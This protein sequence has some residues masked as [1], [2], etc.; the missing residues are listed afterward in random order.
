LWTAIASFVLALLL[1][2]IAITFFK[3]AALV[4]PGSS[5]P[6]ALMQG[7][8]ALAIAVILGLFWCYAVWRARVEYLA[9]A[10]GPVTVLPFQDYTHDQSDAERAKELTARFENA[11]VQTKIYGSTAIPSTGR[12]NDFLSIVELAGERLTGAWGAASRL[13][14]V[15]APLSAY[16]VRC[17]MRTNTDT[18]PCML[19]VELSRLPSTSIAPFVIRSSSWDEAVRGAAHHVAA[20]ILPRTRQCG[21]APWRMWRGL[22]LD[23]EFFSTYQDFLRYRL[24]RN[25]DEAMASLR[26]AIKFDPGN[27]A[28][29][30]DLGKLQERMQ[31]YLDAL[32]TYD[33][34]IT[35]AARRDVRLSRW[36]G[37]SNTNDEIGVW[38]DARRTRGLRADDPVILIARYRHA[39]LLGLSEKLAEQWWT[40]KERC[41][42]GVHRS[43]REERRAHLR[44]ALAARFGKRYQHLIV[45]LPTDKAAKRPLCLGE[46]AEVRNDN[47]RRRRIA[48]ARIYFTMLA[49]YEYEHLVRDY[50]PRRVQDL[51]WSAFHRRRPPWLEVFTRIPIAGLRR[52][53]ERYRWIRV[54][55]TRGYAE[56][57][58]QMRILP[59]EAILMGLPWSSLR[60][61]M[62]VSWARRA[63]YGPTPGDWQVADA[64]SSVGEVGGRSERW[65]FRGADD[66]LQHGWPPPIED[67]EKVVQ[68]LTGGRRFRLRT[69]RAHYNAACTLALPLLPDGLEIPK[70]APPRI[71][72][73]KRDRDWDTAA[74]SA[75]LMELERAVAR[76][77][78]GYVAQQRDWLLSEDPDLDHLR[79]RPEFKDFEATTFGS[80]GAAV[81][82]GPNIHIW[83]QSTYV[84]RFISSAAEQMAELWKGRQ[85]TT[86]VSA[87]ELKTWI[88]EEMAGWRLAEQLAQDG[89][90]SRTRQE[91]GAEIRRTGRLPEMAN[92][93][94]PHPDFTNR[95]LHRQVASMEGNGESNLLALRRRGPG[96]SG[97]VGQ[98]I[99][100]AIYKADGRLAQLMNVLRPDDDASGLGSCCVLARR[101]VMEEEERG[102][103]ALVARWSAEPSSLS[104]VEDVR[105]WA[106]LST[107]RWLALAEWFDDSLLG[108]GSL[109]D[110]Q[111]CFEESLPPSTQADI[112]IGT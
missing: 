112:V 28:L 6:N 67:L 85:Y 33:D 75:A 38:S 10:P 18:A 64:A 16:Q 110:R 34:I 89:R 51:V 36:W 54:P 9:V 91:V 94:I 95:V 76:A 40:R 22:R 56:R 106:K 46:L 61:A 104:T 58:E 55:G 99:D 68:R 1:C 100:E 80:I 62:A 44:R 21:H 73:K 96:A 69:W 12:P 53:F 107:D 23:P 92:P 66:L 32:L 50:A 86:S 90:D 5:G 82:R 47:G 111:A 35:V 24:G 27:L 63:V 8:T 105:R 84:A 3:P 45:R 19:I 81:E 41:R 29:R 11:L 98:R 4:P 15:L 25:F 101:S 30:L 87:D 60:R 102:L 108:H 109:A 103:R 37:S 20:Y 14:R 65:A 42:K 26:A 59:R 39:Q 17:S 31:M 78:S 97:S 52:V 48:E 71:S 2:L 49:Q 93:L 88:D 57:A 7:T 74:T 77:D 13:V 83:E 79:G 72:P 43:S 70:E